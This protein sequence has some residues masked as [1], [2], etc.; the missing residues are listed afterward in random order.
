LE[1]Q[2]VLQFWDIAYAFHLD[3]RTYIVDHQAELLVQIGALVDL[4]KELQSAYM[5]T[6]QSNQL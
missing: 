3:I 1:I 4:E 5:S 2:Y 6:N